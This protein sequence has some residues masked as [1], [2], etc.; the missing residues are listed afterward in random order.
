MMI[1]QYF[2]M[3]DYSVWEVILN[4]DSPIPTRVVDGVVQPI[5]PTT[6]EQ[7]LAK[8]NE[9][10]ARGTL[11]MAL[12]DKHQLKFNIHKDA[13]SLMDAIKKR[14]GGNKET[15][16]MQKTLPNQQYEN[17]I[18]SS[19][20]SLDQIHDRLQKLI[21]QLEILGESLSQ[22]DINLK[23]LRSLPTEWRTHTLIWRNKTDLEDQSLDDLFNN[24]KIYEAEVKIS[25]VTSV[26]AASTKIPVSALP[27][28]DTLSDAKMA[29]LTM[30]ARRFLLRTERNLEANGTNSIWVDMSK[31]ECY[32]CHKRR[33]FA[34]ECSMMVLVAMTGA[35]RQIKNQQTM[36][37]WHS[38]PQVLPVLIMSTVFDCDEMFSSE[39]DVSMPTSPVHDRPSVKPVE[40]PIAADNLRKGFPKS[41]GHRH[42]WN[43]KS[44]FVCKSLIHLI[45]D[46]DYYEKKMV[47]NPIKNHDMR[48]N[49]QHYARMTHPHPQRNIQVSYGLGP[50]KTLT[51]LFDVKGNPH[52]ALKDKGVID[53]GYSRHMTWNISNLFDFEEKNGGYVAFVGN[54]KGGKIT[55]KGKIRIG[56]LD[57]DD[58]YFVKE[59]KF[60]L[61]SVSKM[62][63][64]N[65]NVLFTDTECIVLSSDFKLSD[66]NHVLLR[67][68]REHNMYNVDLK[69]IVPSGDL[70][71]LF[72]KATLD[73]SNLWHR[74]LGHINI[75]T[76]NKL[77]KDPLAKFDGKADEG[78]LVGYSVSSKAFRV[79]NSR[80]RIVQ[81]TLHINFLENQ[82][83]VAGSG[84]S[85]LFDI[86]TLTQTM[87]YQLIIAGNQ[88]DSSADPPNTDVAATFE[89]KEPESEVHVSPSSSAKTK[90]H[91]DR[92]KR[93]A[94][95]KSLIELSTRVRDLINDL[96]N[97]SITT[98]TGLVGPS[99]TAVSL[100]LGLDG[101][102]SYVD[103][104]Q[105]PDDPDMPALEDITYSDD[106]E[107]VGV[108]VDFSNL[109]TNIT[110]SPIPTT[111]VHK[112]HPVTQII[113]DLSTA[114]QTRSM[115]RMVKEQGGLTQINDEDFHTYMFAC[116]LSQEEPKR[117]HQA[118]KD[119]SWIE[120]MQE[121]LLQFKMQKVWVLVDLPKGKRAIGSKWEEGIDY[122]EVFALVARI[123]AIRLF[124]AY[125]SFMGFMMDVKSAFLY[126]TIKKEVY[127]CQPPGFK[128]PDYPD[129]VYKLVKAL[130]GL[131]QAPRACS[132]LMLFGLTID[133][134]HLLLLGHKVSAVSEGFEQIIDFLNTSVIQYAL[135]V[136]PTIYVSC[137]KQFWSFVSLKKTNDVVRLQALIDRRKVIITEATIRQALRLDDAESID[138]LPKEEIFA[139]LA[140]M[141][142]HPGMSLVH[143]WLQLSSAF[144]QT[145]DVVRLQ[146]LIDRR[147]VIITEATIRQAL[148]LDDAESIDCLPKEEIFAKLARMSLVRNV[149]SPS[150]FYMYPRFL[151]LM[152]N[153]QLGDLSS[154][155]IK[156][157]SYA[158]KQKVFA[159]MRRVGKG[160]SGVDTLLFDGML[161]PQQVQ[162]DVATAV[163]DE[164]AA[165]EI[166]VEPTP[167]SPIPATTPPPQQ[168][169]I[170]SSSHVESTP[171][172]SL[173]QSPIA[174]PSSPHH[175]NLL[176]GKI[177]QAIEITKLKQR[178][179][180]LKKK[181]KRMHPNKR[182]IAEL[183]A[184]EDVTLEEVDAEKDVAVQGRLP[185]SQALVYHLDLEHAQK[186]L[187][188]QEVDKAEPAKVEEVLEVVTAAKMMTKIV[189]TATTTTTAHVPKASA[190]RRR[191]DMIIQDPKDVATA[192][193]SMQTEVKSKD[194]GKGI[195]VEEPKPLKRQ[196]QIEQD[197]AYARELE[198]ELNANIN[199][200]EHFNSI[201]AFLE[202]GEKELEEE[203]GKRKGKSLEEKAAKKQK[204]DE[205]VEEL[206]T[207]IQIVP[208]DED[209]VY[210]EATPLALKVLVVDYQIHTENNKPYYKII[211]A[212]GTHQLF[213]SFISLLR[214]FDRDDLEMLWKIVQERFASSEPKNFS[215]DFLLN[216]LRTMFEKPN[217]EAN[218]WKNQ[219][220]RYGLKVKSWKL[221]EVCGVH[222][223][224]FTTTQMILLVER[225]YHL[226]RFTLEQMLNNTL[227]S[228][229]K[230]S[231]S[232]FGFYPRLLTPYI[233][234]KD[235]DL[236]KS[237][238]SQVVVFAAKLPILNPNEFDLWKMRIEH[239]FLMTDYSLWEVI[240]NGD[241]PIPTRVVD[242][243]VQPNKTDLE[244]QS[245]DDLF[246]N[247]EI[248]EAEI[249]SS[250]SA[251][252]TTQNIAFVSSQNTDSTN[253]SGSA[254]TSVF[255][256]STKVLVSALP[257]MD[258]LS[259]AII[260]S[261]FASQSNSLQLDNDDLKQIDADDLEEMDLKWQMAMITMR[262]RSVMVLVAMIGAFRQ[263]KNQQTMP[264]WH[265]PPQVLPV[266]II[267]GNAPV[268]L[269]KKFEKAEQ[270]KDE[271]KLKLEKFQTSS[272]NLSKLL[273]SQITDKTRLGYDNQVFNS[274]V[275]DCDE[276]ISSES[277]VNI[278]TS[279]VHDRYKSGEGYHDVPPPYTGTFMPPKPNLVFYDTPTINETVPTVLHVSDSKDESEGEPMPTQKA[280]SFVQ[281]SERVKT[282]R[283]SVKPVEH[284][285]PAENLR[286]DI[287][288]SRGHRHSWNRKAFLTRSKI[289]PLTA[290]RPVT[291]DL[292]Q[293]KVQHQRPTKH[294]VTKAHSPIRKPIN[295]R[296]S[297]THSN[298]HQKV[299]TVKATQGNPQHA[300]KDKGVID[301]G[302]SRHMTRN[303]SYLSDF[304]EINGGYVAFGGN[305]NGGKIIGK[306]NGKADEGFLVGYSV[307]SKAFRVFNS[308][309]RIV[310]KTLHINFLENQPNVVGSRP[311]WLFDI[312]ILTQSINYQPVVAGNQPNSSAG[313]QEHFNA[314]KTGEENVQ[315]YVLFPLW[316][317]GSKD[318]QNTDA[319][320]T[321][322]VKEPESEVHVSLSSSDK[323]KK[324][325]DKTK[326]E[327]KGKSPVEL[328]TGVRDSSDDF[329][330]FFDNSTNRVNAA[331][332]LV[333]AVRPNSTNNTNTFSATGPFNNIVSL[334]FKLGE[335]SS[336]VASSQYPDDPDMPALEDITYLDDEEDVGA[337]ADFSNLETNITVNPIPTTRVHKDHPVTQI[338]GDLSSAPQT[339]KEPKRVHQA[340]KDPSWIEAM[341]EEI[342]QFKMQKVWVLVDLPKDVKS[343]FLYG[344]IE[345]EMYVCQP[346]G[347]KDTDYPD[348]VYVD[349]IIFRST[350]KYLCKAFEKL[351]KDKFQMSSMGE[352]TFFLG[353]QVKQKQDRI[354]ISKDKYVAEI[355]RKFGLTDGKLASTPIDT[356]KPL[357]KD[358]DG[359]DVDVHTYRSMI[360]S[361]M[362]LTLSR[363]DIMF[364]VCACARFQV[365]PKAS[366][367]LVV[368]RIF[369][370][371]KGKPHLGLWFPKD[372]PFNLVAYSNSDYARV[373]LDRKST[374]G[375]IFAE[376]ARMRYEKPSTKLTF[377]KAFFSTQ[378]K[379]LIHTILQCMSVK[380]TAWNEFSSFM[381]L[382]VICLAT[383]LSGVDTPLFDEILVP[384]QVHDD[385]ADAVEDE[386]AANEISA[387]PTPP[388]PTPA[389][390][391]P[392]QQ[393]LI[394]SPSQ[395]ASTPPPSPHQSPISQPSSPPPQQPYQH[396]DISQSA[397]AIL[398]QLL[399]TCVTLIKKV[400]TL[401]QDK[402]A[403][404]I[405][406]NKLKQRVGRLEKKRKSKTSGFKR[407]RKVGTAQ[408]VESSADTI[409]DDQ[410]DVSKQ[411][412]KLLNW[413]PM[414][415][416]LKG[417]PVK[418]EEVLEMV[419][420]AKLMTE[421][422]TTATT[423]ITVALVPK[424]S[425][426]RRRRGV[427]IHDP[428]EAA[429]ASLSVQSEDEAFARELEAELNANINWN[430]VIEQVKRKERQDN[431]V[432]RYQALKR[433]HPKNFSNDFLLNALK[434][435]FEKPNVKGNIW[436]NQRGIY[437]LAKVKSWKLLE[438][439][440][441][442]I[443]T[444]TTTQMILLVESRYHLIRFTL[445]QILN[446]VRLEVEEESEVSL[447]LLRFMRRQQQEGY[448]LE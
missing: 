19:S 127:V 199:W 229:T 443:I 46:C 191:R 433:K 318:P 339:R 36:P 353:L 228:Q 219:K 293:T 18:G 24:L 60:N 415:I 112:D 279:P 88:P 349:D 173:H 134:V 14:F 300:L 138:C 182:G 348:K 132:K 303:I 346:L 434:T 299:T 362:Y 47:Q 77:V 315:Q 244:D 408:R 89:V 81:E 432:I 201:W 175:N 169:F 328:S 345:E 122:E 54:P 332:T 158:L 72:A 167:P 237:K 402:I 41:R 388:S 352:L 257:N 373:G 414:R 154:H 131:H 287:P 82:P 20:E 296:P 135:M 417:E 133:A 384:Q 179:R 159:N 359:E 412:G 178:V 389:T 343:A 105:Y 164:D 212:D 4:G 235:K 368:K 262:A 194:K 325:D 55:G 71:C 364:F 176:N 230:F 441:V 196:A 156:Y 33:H 78:F 136:N 58:V 319:D 398:N 9:L 338:I 327:A 422:V 227:S 421:V 436:K 260:Y 141:R 426:P 329:E 431:T 400:G 411:G 11:L 130:Y 124:L 438:S 366:H 238:D 314:D 405:E 145:N 263:M 103:P 374:T 189:T 53:S 160:F 307:S 26:S 59:L 117:V 192:S 114:P 98:L 321:F 177:A 74:R 147:K 363:P 242:G 28:V 137:I 91:D 385:F 61:F 403:Q 204:I 337:E 180:K 181:G 439:C 96:K 294:G 308:R 118:L 170:P 316:S 291:T 125:A 302:C 90:K 311:T 409:M 203:D 65:N 424:A 113:G 312:D 413:M 382:A 198:A 8:K 342:L 313:I 45:K 48:G 277:D 214:N 271:L 56:K 111:R 102:S 21:S 283:L 281:T 379:F 3:T 274:I 126:E 234:L 232:G 250:S 334:N 31:V 278:H 259:N 211:I 423:T 209:D 323:T 155:T 224:T 324:H 407:L 216:T 254:V 265:S 369:R 435:M 202:K 84:L 1:E 104:S 73:E 341:Q 34:R 371:L 248:Y 410:E 174:Q 185:E 419:T 355:L 87:N 304:E 236:Q 188:M 183:D 428:E 448:K 27:N 290:T 64:K 425:A 245:L 370:Y 380:R 305:P 266:L 386:D 66:K 397:I 309:T 333:T 44:C 372:S 80:T 67:V 69:K 330:E 163:E 267:R 43:R 200:N 258:N 418:V 142:G 286:E 161:V 251:S 95:G 273:T 420:A 32:N 387:K 190:P 128:D 445:E 390:T 350:N 225:R 2:L 249:K 404:A 12:P 442:Y 306:F 241:S 210:T 268:E 50:Q 289:V 233:S 381:A 347:F 392:P 356:E 193:L 149:D 17:F 317:T 357:L 221:I 99:N 378:W 320:A 42:S 62:C 220:G 218:I 120:A 5:A 186:V 361:L 395:V 282:P 23:F 86:D 116:F 391:P 393:E 15:K 30:R 75:K 172:P 106:E 215:D 168:E 101:K 335:K 123:E 83:N 213:L 25:A 29:M 79:F 92:T 256:A 351:M 406:I 377:Y 246:N 16:K 119:P 165:N 288:K 401:E 446:N 295:L 383:G 444:F 360:G 35:F 297:P 139:K 222:I 270:E 344:T 85:W 243:V 376:L 276:L 22:E 10:K 301:S 399:E 255:A 115:D 310:Q 76:M 7:R 140:R 231:L 97:F 275:F 110:V 447:E 375:E 322:E 63:D 298:F 68:P 157:T 394:P 129:K 207:H 429:T 39:S 437:G 150:K 326:R 354:F 144:Q 93:E 240:L 264:S 416:S 195:I 166:S 272:K 152:V 187:S 70:T 284:P 109:E 269:R 40:H 107:A 292:P 108:E 285:I 197:E 208:N 336:Y 13:K 205:E 38:P 148:R 52:H 121:E 94:K 153:D 239:Y 253:E 365:T 217:V 226:T 223:I 396:E 247:L 427:I 162:D 261:F 331:N 151:Q 340:L 146:A 440:G 171:P 51:F 252:P 6:A 37:S 143:P 358:P 57:F 367:L 430:E 100:T 184:D 206:K 49:H 280:P